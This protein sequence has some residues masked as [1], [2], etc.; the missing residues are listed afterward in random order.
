M[1]DSKEESQSG[2]VESESVE[3]SRRKRKVVIEVDAEDGQIGSSTKRQ[4]R[5]NGEQKSEPKISLNGSSSSSPSSRNNFNSSRS[6]SNSFGNSSGVSSSSSAFRHVSTANALSK[7]ASYEKGVQRKSLDGGGITGTSESEAKSGNVQ[8]RERLQS[9]VNYDSSP[10]SDATSGSPD[11]DS[12][13]LET[14][15]ANSDNDE[16][17]SGNSKASKSLY[18]SDLDDTVNTNEKPSL[19]VKQDD[20]PKISLSLSTPTSTAGKFFFRR[21]FAPCHACVCLCFTVLLCHCKSCEW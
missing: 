5:S 1:S 6:G 9:L 17:L 19:S 2:S 16:Q 7:I 11:V 18:D 15:D 4:K 13:S 12:P 8:K 3:E 10:D 20:A 14:S 21:P